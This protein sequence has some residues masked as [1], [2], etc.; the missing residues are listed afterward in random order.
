MLL[1]F[2]K[3]GYDYDKIFSSSAGTLNSLVFHSGDLDKMVNLWLKIKT[4][5]VY[6]KYPW[7]L[8]ASYNRK[9]VHDSS[10]LKKLIYDNVN[11][12]GIKNNPKDFWINTTDLTNSAAYS[13]EVKTFSNKDDLVTF[14][15]ASAS[16]PIY[17][18][19]VSFEGNELCDSGVVNNYS[20][21][22][23][24][25]QGCDTLVLLLPAK[26]TKSKSAKNILEL[27]G[28]VMGLS[29][30]SY[31]ERETKAI[32]KIN[33][34]LDTINTAIANSQCSAILD[35]KDFPRKI[36]LIMVYPEMESSFD[37]L[38]FEYKDIDRQQLITYGYKRC[39]EILLK[40]LG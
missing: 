36:K 30:Q 32:T 4:K 38:D 7:D 19:T 27:I 22:E 40:E 10:P 26:P 23:S 29:M 13:R 37:F 1:A 16:P 8:L 9:W 39:Q 34:I 33:S 35:G 3:L 21:A 5:D 2:N 17:F 11:F 15:F 12:P 6:T 31:M 25:G 18:P 14:A 24:I 28:Q 20:I